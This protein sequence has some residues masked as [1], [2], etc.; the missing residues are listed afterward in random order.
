MRFPEISLPS[1]SRRRML[2]WLGWGAAGG[3]VVVVGKNV[4]Y[5]V[6]LL[7]KSTNLLANIPNATTEKRLGDSKVE[8]E[9]LTVNVKG[10]E[11]SR[12][13]KQ[14]KY[15]RENL[16][17]GVELEMISIPGGTFLM[18]TDDEEIERLEK[19]FNVDYF[20][21][22]RPQHQVTV[23]AL[24]MGKF[25]VTQQ[26]W[27]Q[28]AALPKIKIDLNPNPAYF[29]GETLPV[30]LISW[31]EAVEFCERLSKKTGKTYRLPSEAE[32]EY[33]CRAETTTPFH[34]GATITGE[35]ANYDATNIFAQEA[36]GIYR[37]KT[38]SVGSFPA[39]AFGLYDVHGNVWEW[40]ADTWHENYGVAPTDATPWITKNAQNSSYRVLRGGSWVNLPR[41]CRSATRYGNVA[42]TRDG[43]NGFRVVCSASRTS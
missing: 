26:E 17:N 6:S 37:G 11:I 1:I 14:A 15:Y 8:F 19:K 13:S 36:K 39:N 29:K 24:S 27:Q 5:L 7:P 43:N 23:P 38:T 22:E 34:F 16:G 9:V 12:E 2:Q 28:V 32:W 25:P 3:S 10:E 18:G 21:R 30:E 35:L 40:C 4:P 31:S 33:A 41:N 20:N 42:G